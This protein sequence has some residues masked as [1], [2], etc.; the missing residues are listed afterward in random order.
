MLKSKV[1][2]DANIF[3]VGIE[4]RYSDFN[5]SF[6]NIKNLCLIPILESFTNIIIHRVVYD[7]LDNNARKLIDK[8]VGKNITIVDEDDLYGKDPKY[9]DIFNKIAGD[10]LVQYSRG[11]T[12]DAGEV[13]SLAYAA[14]HG[15]NYFTSKEIMV[16]NISYTVSELKNID[17]VTFDVIVLI[18]FIYFNTKS[19]TSNN[20]AL[21]AIYKRFC[22]DV[23][24]RHGLPKTLLEYINESK[25]YLV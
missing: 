8:Y 18:D 4:Y 25:E 12:K 21:K 9:T 6:E 20:K 14:Y 1:M 17:I 5:C 10:G 2:F 13:Y 16:E 23:I 11:K 19:D 24:K 7:E 15:I 22:E 3:M